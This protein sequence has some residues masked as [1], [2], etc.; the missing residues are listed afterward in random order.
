MAAPEPWAAIVL[1]A[2]AGERLG[3]L[4]KA[5]IRLDGTPLITRLIDA[6]EQAGATTI[7]VVLGHHA[8]AIAAA[9]AA[10]KNLQCVR[11]GPSDRPADSLRAGLAASAPQGLPVMV[12][13]ADQPL[14]DAA[15][16]LALTAAWRDRPAGSD[17]VVPCAN[18]APG[19]PVMLAPV[20]IDDLLASTPPITGKAWRQ[21]HAAQVFCWPGDDPAYHVDLDTLDDVERLRATGRE[22][23]LP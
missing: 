13:L 5:L 15:A 9:L 23:V 19:N 16:L 8:A 7:V 14:I 20:V 18:D 4:P 3:G 1:A 22:V 2:G 17:M 21:Q 10:R 11:I 12:C 6:L